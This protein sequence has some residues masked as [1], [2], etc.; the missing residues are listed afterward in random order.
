MKTKKKLLSYRT[1]VILF[2]IITL[3]SAI[4]SS[5]VSAKG[6]K[7]R[8]GWYEQSC[9]Q[10]GTSP[11][12]LSGY[13]YEYLQKLSIY[14]GWDYEFVNGTWDE[15]ESRLK[16]GEVD[17]VGYVCKTKER[18]KDY[19]FCDY[20]AGQLS[21]FLSSRS[22][23][24]RFTAYSF[25]SL[26]NMTI[27]TV[28]S[29]YRM[30]LLNSF[31]KKY[32][33]HLNY[34]IFNTEEECT[35]AL[36]KKDVDLILCS[37]SSAFDNQ[38]LI[39]RFPKQNFYFAVSKEKPDILRELN[40]A[41][42]EIL[43][44][45]SEYNNE[46]AE[47][48]FSSP[49]D[50]FQSSFTQKEQ[51]FLNA[52]DPITVA[53][54]ANQYPLSYNDGSPSGFVFSYLKLITEQTNLQFKVKIFP[55]FTK[56]IESVQKN[57][58][59][60]MLQ[61]PDNLEYAQKYN[62]NLTHPFLT[63]ETGL[64]YEKGTRIKTIGVVSELVDKN[65]E[66]DKHYSLVYFDDDASCLEALKNG[67]VDASFVNYYVYQRSTM[68]H[69]DTDLTYLPYNDTRVSYCM[70]VSS[71]CNSYLY[72]VLD[73][74]INYIGSAE[75]MSLL[76]SVTSI[77]MKT[78]IKDWL[79]KERYM[80]L[81]ISVILIVIIFSVII[82]FQRSLSNMEKNAN[83]VL[84]EKNLELKHANAAKS[85]FL[86]QTSHDL[87]TP[88]NAIMGLTALALDEPS[89]NKKDFYL[90]QISTSSEFLLGLI[91]DVLDM[92]KIENGAIVLNP[93]PY[94]YSDFSYMITT[95]ITPLCRN[96]NIDFIFE[97]NG[98]DETMVVDHTRFNQIFFNLLTNAVK[99]TPADGTITFSL[100]YG[101]INDGYIPLS[102]M[103]ADTGIGMSEEFM[104]NMYEPFMQEHRSNTTPGSG[105]GLA[106]VKN[107]V[108]LMDGTIH[109][110]SHLNEGTIFLIELTVPI[111][112][113]KSVDEG[114]IDPIAIDRALDSK[115]VLLVD[116]HPLNLE[117]AKKVL[118]KKKINVTIASD[119]QQAVNM[120]KESNPGFYDIILMDIR[121]PVLNGLEATKVIRSLDRSDAKTIPII[122]MTANTFDEDKKKSE[123]AGM[124]AH[125]GKPIVPKELFECIYK[126]VTKN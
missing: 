105:L 70:G 11:N 81:M 29:S 23:D 32:K 45:D 76:T 16:N 4:P 25:N 44:T 41:I 56:A 100:S 21:L 115:N 51:S 111:S 61:V 89:V 64:L 9:L 28:S 108:D 14:T 112:E 31:S 68:S 19:N 18:A 87:R 30:D 126:W 117:V 116:D 86:A 37:D 83:Q 48:Y 109:V 40:L 3:C 107:M 55:T 35:N 71:S 120:F 8:I 7:I 73:K 57:E 78:S 97:S 43:S 33:L 84:A 110:E 99:Y 50:G 85:E 66:K 34:K 90:G 54:V 1:C 60:I 62:V 15:C 82:S 42:G 5:T 80:I 53:I 27:G 104:E 103:V 88:M 46:L 36:N 13:N 59:D 49:S 24:Y 121:M 106:I 79:Y 75:S 93:E 72:H 12:N 39:Y 118:E 26:K 2:I 91:N 38:K 58:T 17:I 124:V 63:I 10:E 95:M 125:L 47:K 113:N 69:T 102:F 98:F 101:D 114:F 6:K 74:S 92:D 94:H 96:K 123:E 122:A 77:P 67:E 65:L 22:S 119:G 52:S 20:A